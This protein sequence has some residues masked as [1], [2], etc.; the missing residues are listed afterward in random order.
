MI[1]AYNI[2]RLIGSGGMGS[3]YEAFNPQI[4]RRAAIKTLSKRISARCRI[5][6]EIFN[7]AR[8]VNIINHQAW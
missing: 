2:I 4:E 6:S 3:V 7:E 5:H 8:A 1:G